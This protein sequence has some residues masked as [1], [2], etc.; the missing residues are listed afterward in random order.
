MPQRDDPVVPVPDFLGRA[1]AD[2]PA[3]SDVVHLDNA[4]SALPPSIVVETMIDH[5]QREARVGGYR[6]ASE[7][8]DEVEGVYQSLATLI[9]AAPSE[10]AIVEN[11]TRAWDM[12][13]Y[14][15]PFRPGDRVLISRAEYASNAIALL[16]LGRRKHIELVLIDDDQDG[17]IDLDLLEAELERG[18]AMVSLTHLPTNGGLINPAAAV[19]ALCREHGACFVLDACQS[20]G[21]IP[22]D[23]DEIGCDVLS[24][25]GRKFLRGPRGTGLLYVRHEWI[26]RLEPPF[27]DLHA[28]TWTGDDTYV[29]RGDARR[30]ENWET[31]IAAKLGL[32]AAAAYALDIGIDN[33]W[34]YVEQLAASLRRRLDG[35]AG[36]QVRDKG[37]QRSGIV[38]FTIDDQDPHFLQRSLAEVGINSSVSIADHARF[39]LPHRGLDSV[40]RASV[41]YYNT[42]DEIDALVNAAAS[43]AHRSV[44]ERADPD[45]RRPVSATPSLT[46]R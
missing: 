13:V 11:A 40:V 36:V 35:C 38:T 34:P 43:F 8:L 21:Q 6:A 14:G 46:Q 2:T 30:F 42:T 25:T 4:G 24:A 31:N 27:L 23:V 22:I 33:T 10:I 15:F 16:H 29:V 37:I 7:A 32:G 44:H 9:G 39:D 1:R 41:H 20:V 3:A 19:G 45:K 26:E 18:A 28:A 5:L 17:Q 12:A